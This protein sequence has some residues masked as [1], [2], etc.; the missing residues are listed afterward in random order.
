MALSTLIYVNAH[1]TDHL[2]FEVKEC[3]KKTRIG[4]FDFCA[5][6]IYLYSTLSLNF[7]K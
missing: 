2:K 5:P 6:I 7:Q 3:V 4:I 1:F